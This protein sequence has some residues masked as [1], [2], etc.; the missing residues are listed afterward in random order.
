MRSA[1]IPIASATANQ[2]M[3]AF[4]DL[5]T[6]P[7]PGTFNASITHA[8]EPGIGPLACAWARITQAAERPIL[9]TSNRGLG[10]SK[11]AISTTHVR[12]CTKWTLE[13]LVAYASVV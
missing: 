5:R 4:Q 9:A 7:A 10:A 11:L 1:R 2:S 6:R 12:L 8:W 3:L 13:T